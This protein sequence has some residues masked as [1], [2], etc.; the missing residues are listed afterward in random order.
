MK[1]PELLTPSVVP[2]I[3]PFAP[4][5]L[6]LLLLTPVILGTVARLL[7]SVKEPELLAPQASPRGWFLCLC[8]LRP[9]LELC[10]PFP[11]LLF[12]PGPFLL[13]LRPPFKS[14]ARRWDPPS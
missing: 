10:P 4:V 14:P 12:P 5:T 13:A 6:Y 1:D 3:M 9:S 8:P 11:W 2:V 7:L